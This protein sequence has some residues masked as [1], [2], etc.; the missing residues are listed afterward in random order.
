M[1]FEDGPGLDI[2]EG[3]RSGRC[4]IEWT[5]GSGRVPDCMLEGLESPWLAIG[6]IGM[7]K[8]VCSSKMCMNK[9][10][11]GEYEGNDRNTTDMSPC[12]DIGSLPKAEYTTV[13]PQ[14]KVEKRI[15]SHDES[16]PNLNKSI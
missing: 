4:G 10:R 11:R 5:M 14:S 2:G 13:E 6:E 3:S 9:N 16:Q 15:S 12:S 1:R 8:L 7:G